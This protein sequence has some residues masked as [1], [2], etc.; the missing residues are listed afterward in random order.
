VFVSG[1]SGDIN[2]LECP[3][4]GFTGDLVDSFTLNDKT[5]DCFGLTVNGVQIPIYAVMVL[6]ADQ[7]AFALEYFAESSCVSSIGRA[8]A[9]FILGNCQ[10]LPDSALSARISDVS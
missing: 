2:T 9:Q 1:N 6:P 8:P 4:N 3:T 10:G 5:S 7:G